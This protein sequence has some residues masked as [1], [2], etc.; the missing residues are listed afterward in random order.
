MGWEKKAT[1]AEAVKAFLVSVNGKVDLEASVEKFRSV[2][3]KTLANQETE[4]SLIV[5]CMNGLFD[6]FPG[7]SL[8]LDYI[9]SH[10]V[11]AMAKQVPELKDPTVFGQ[12]SKRVEEVLHA[13]TDQPEVPA[14]GDRPAQPA[15]TNRAFAMKRGKGGGF[16]RKSDQAAKPA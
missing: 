11:Q 4:D 1:Q 9:K 6:Q 16:Y 15:I 5:T 10:T 3:L 12:V 7:A 13:L 2:A 8:N 14:E